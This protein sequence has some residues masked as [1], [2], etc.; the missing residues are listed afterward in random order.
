MLRSS[1]WILQDIQYSQIELREHQTSRSSRHGKDRNILL[2][3]QYK[4]SNSAAAE[5]GGFKAHPKPIHAEF[6]QANATVK[7]A[8]PKEKLILLLNLISNKDRFK[9]LHLNIL[10]LLCFWKLKPLL[11]FLPEQMINVSSYI[12]INFSRISMKPQ[13]RK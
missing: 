5:K 2:S 10:E 3:K 6:Q 11:G 4:C 13:G 7:R 1:Q 12:N 8:C 9:T